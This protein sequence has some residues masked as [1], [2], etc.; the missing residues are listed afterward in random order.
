MIRTLVIGY[1][2]V[3]RADDGVAY[4]VVNALR[5]RLGQKPLADDDSGLQELGAQTDSILLAQLVP[6]LIDTLADY[7]QIIFVDAHVREDV[8]EL[9]CAPVSSEYVTSPFTHH[10]TPGM[11]LALL[12]ALHQRG[13]VGYLV[14]IRGRDFDFG[15]NLSPAVEQLV[16]V[17][18]E[19]IWERLALTNREC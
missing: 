4:H 1:G 13:P 16:P 10:I 17:A 15:R 9:F 3:D 8:P 6:E 14:S 2:N 12:H 11:L 7:D 5:Q 19:R 18:V